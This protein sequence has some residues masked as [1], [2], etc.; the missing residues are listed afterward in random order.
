[1]FGATRNTPLTIP[2]AIWIAMLLLAFNLHPSAA[3][4]AGQRIGSSPVQEAQAR[5]ASGNPGAAIRLLTPWVRLHPADTLARLLL[6]SADEAAGDLSGAENQFQ[7]ALKHAPSDPRALLALGMFYD[8]RRHPEK[9]EPLLAKTAK[10]APDSMEARLA[11]AA[12]L[13]ELHRYSEAQEAIRGVSPPESASSKISYYR[14]KAA[15]ELGL[16]KADEAARS[17]ETALSMAPENQNLRLATGVAEFEAGN[18]TDA[19]GLLEPLFRSTHDPRCGLYLLQAQINAHADYSSTLDSLRSMAAEAGNGAALSD[20]I[21]NALAKSGH[22]AEALNDFKAA[23]AAAPTNQIALM[24]LASTQLRLGQPASAYTTAARALALGDSAAIESLLGEIQE[25]R[26]MNLDAVH[27]DQKAVALGAEDEEYWLA[28]GV[29][30]LRHETYEPA[31]AVFRQA[32][33]RF[34]KSLKIRVALG[35]TE[36]FLEQ[37]PQ[38]IQALMA[39]SRE[40]QDSALPLN[41][42]G[43]IQLQPQVTPDAAAVRA[44]CQFARSHPRGGGAMAYCGALLARAAHDR[45]DPAP[46]AAAVERLRQAVELAPENATARCELGKALEWLKQWREAGAQMEECVRLD[47]GFAE[48]HYRLAEIYRHEGESARAQQ[49]IKL[50]NEAVKQMIAANAQRDAA[51]KKFLYTL[52]ASRQP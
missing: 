49:Q 33:A 36:Y 46:P 9:A 10:L 28:L 15:I 50:H 17:M 8:R 18:W 25:R 19:A 37:Y 3:V 31:L 48:G 27:H 40:N 7:L 39:A 4:S 23:A 44:I 21:G 26:G 38:A 32:A 12:D 1:M 6:G 29:E 35:M 34:P 43:Q 22:D 47:P 11:W 24:D 16:G 52:R 41:L 42:L 30:L 14:M 13:A 45:G 20:A 2:G 51:M 5:M